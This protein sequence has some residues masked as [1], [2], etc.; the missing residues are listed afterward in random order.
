MSAP[1]S[2]EPIH[3]DAPAVE[4]PAP[5][6]PTPLEAQEEAAAWEDVLRRRQ[7]LDALA[8]YVYTLKLS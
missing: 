4:E 3:E 6:T 1:A 7:E 5:V 2:D 8:G